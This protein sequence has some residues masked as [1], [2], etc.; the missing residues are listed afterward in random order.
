MVDM[1][2][3]IRVDGVIQHEPASPFAGHFLEDP[4]VGD[5]VEAA[6]VSINGWLLGFD[7]P[8][9]GV[10]VRVNGK[11]AVRTPLGAFDRPDLV[12]AFG[13]HPWAGNAAFSTSVAVHG[14]QGRVEFEVLG[15]A[16]DGSR[17]PI[18][19]ISGSRCWSGGSDVPVVSIII[20]CYNQ[21]HFLRNA[22]ESARHQSYP[23]IEVVVVDDGSTDNTERIAREYSGVL[24]VRQ[25]NTGLAGA[26]NTGIRSSIGEFMVF[27]DADDML[28]PNAVAD[29]LNALQ[30]CPEA[31]YTF[32][33]Y[34]HL[35][36]A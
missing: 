13:V 3:L 31:A 35:S 6:G 4:A 32:G 5:V 17:R 36:V 27:L 25:K 22:I 1:G 7:R 18:A 33:R 23:H 19:T 30:G 34:A 14:R 29:G 9:M 11:D 12:A 28:L 15:L 2:A 20:P 24:C 8:A 16:S 21:A 26:R 10:E